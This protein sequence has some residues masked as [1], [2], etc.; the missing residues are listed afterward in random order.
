M[1]VYSMVVWLEDSKKVEWLA[2]R[3]SGYLDIWLAG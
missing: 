3:I 1:N 2:D